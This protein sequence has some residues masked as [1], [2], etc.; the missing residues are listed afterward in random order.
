MWLRFRGRSRN[1]KF[2][3][4]DYEWVETK[5]RVTVYLVMLW[6][7]LTCRYKFCRFVVLTSLSSILENNIV[8]RI[9]WGMSTT[10]Q[11]VDLWLSYQKSFL[12][13]CCQFWHAFVKNFPQSLPLM[14]QHSFIVEHHALASS[15]DDVCSAYRFLTI[16]VTHSQ[17]HHAN[18][19]SRNWKSSKTILEAQC[20]QLR[21]LGILDKSPVALRRET[22]AQ[23]PCCIGSASE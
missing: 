12:A 19:L 2:T 10:A 14:K 20:Q 22:P 16:P 13:R 4:Y 9:A 5:L 23:Y 3:I 11:Q 17:L 7:Q 15:F 8:W 6:S 1:Q 18:A 21:N